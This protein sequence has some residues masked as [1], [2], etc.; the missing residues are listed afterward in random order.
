MEVRAQVWFFFDFLKRHFEDANPQA[1]GEPAYERVWTMLLNT[2]LR[3]HAAESLRGYLHRL[4]KVHRDEVA[5]FQN[6]QIAY[7]HIRAYLHKHKVDTAYRRSKNRP[8]SLAIEVRKDLVCDF[9]P[10]TG[11]PLPITKT[12]DD[13]ATLIGKVIASAIATYLDLDRSFL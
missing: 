13:R 6:S 10:N 7:E 1:K 8:S 11:R 5:S 4:R 9:D 3:L 2:N 12:I